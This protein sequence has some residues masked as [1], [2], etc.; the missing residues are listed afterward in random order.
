MC[1][2][3]PRYTCLGSALTFDHVLANCA[4]L[5]EELERSHACWTMHW[6]GLTESHLGFV[7]VGLVYWMG[8]G[9]LLGLMWLIHDPTITPNFLA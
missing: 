4:S 1:S 8:H 9:G 7:L 3:Y 5:L 2:S 6:V